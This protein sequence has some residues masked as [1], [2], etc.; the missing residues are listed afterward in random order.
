MDLVVALVFREVVVLRHPEV[1]GLS[2]AYQVAFQVALAFQEVVALSLAY[3]VALAFREGVLSSAFLVALAYQV[4]EVLSSA[5]QVAY[6]VGVLSL[7]AFPCQEEVD[8]ALALEEV[9]IA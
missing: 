7:E 9:D 8:L 1:E 6:Q 2:L 5:F 3:L 4:V